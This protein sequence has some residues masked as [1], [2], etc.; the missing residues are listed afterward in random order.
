MTKTQNTRAL[1]TEKELI[2]TLRISRETAIKMRRDPKDPIPAFR[3][4]R[5][6]LYSL[7]AVLEWAARRERRLE[8]RRRHGEE[9]VGVVRAQA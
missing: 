8:T 7:D 2:E 9:N 3:V 1:L 5:R 6:I 4:G